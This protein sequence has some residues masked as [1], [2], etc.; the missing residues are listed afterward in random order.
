VGLFWDLLQQSQIDDQK[1]KS[2]SLEQRV[3]QLEGQLRDTQLII[4]R[5]LEILERR[6][7]ED[8]DGDGQIG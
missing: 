8:L 2:V 4:N 3:S 5:L 7:G 1:A 6:F